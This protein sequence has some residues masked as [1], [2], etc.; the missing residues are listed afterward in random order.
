MKVTKLLLLIAFLT[1]IMGGA[2]SGQSTTEVRLKDYKRIDK[3]ARAEVSGIV[4]DKRFKDV[5]WVHGDSG[6][7]NRVYPINE[8]GELLPNK[9]SKGLEILEI[10]NK[11][12]EDIAIDEKGNLYIADIGNNCSC[13]KDQSI[14]VLNNPKIEDEESKDF[15]VY[16]ISYEKPGGFLYKFLN[17]SMD[18]E[19]LFIKNEKLYVLTKRYR[20]KDTKLFVLDALVKDQ[21]NEFKLVQSTDFD[22]E[23]TG[24]DYAFGK[25]AVLTY[26]SI[27]IFEDNETD[28]FFDTE[29]HRYAFDGKQIE[30]VTFL[31]PETILIAEEDGEMYKIKL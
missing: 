18:V 26:R 23:V 31:D 14:I 15:E 19:A 11:D 27:W 29:V 4:K 12:W 20:G 3:P 30:S 22:D 10:E 16:K 6:T 7:K 9:D 5:I 21:V 17:Y 28:D 8:K 13:R 24:A 2:V 1:P 25:L